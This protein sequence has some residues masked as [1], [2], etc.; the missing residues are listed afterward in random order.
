MFKS[1]L[2]W[3]AANLRWERGN[4]AYAG[5][6]YGTALRRWLPLAEKG[7]PGAQNNLGVLY[8]HGQGV[9]QDYAEAVK[10]YRLAAAQGF[11]IA[12]YNFGYMHKYGVCGYH[13]KTEADR[14]DRLAEKHWPTVVFGM[15]AR[16]RQLDKE[17]P[18][19][20]Q[21]VIIPS[22]LGKRYPPEYHY[23]DK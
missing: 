2:T 20:P 13:D 3:A 7:Y 6:H 8:Q 9:P 12:Q 17:G 18:G 23:D 14:W 1:F 10:W 19:A 15:C 16:W 5:Q 4:R 21:R 11:F 22:R